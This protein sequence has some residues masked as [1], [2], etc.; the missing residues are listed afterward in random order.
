MH[1][2][3]LTSTRLLKGTDFNSPIKMSVIYGKFYGR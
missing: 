3:S 1:N 2:M